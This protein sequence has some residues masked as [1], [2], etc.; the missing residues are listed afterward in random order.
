MREGGGRQEGCCVGCMHLIRIVNVPGNFCIDYFGRPLPPPATAAPTCG[1]DRCRRT[2][3]AAARRVPRTGPN[4]SSGGRCSSANAAGGCTTKEAAAPPALS[5]SATSTRASCPPSVTRCPCSTRSTSCGSARTW[6]RWAW[7]SPGCSPSYAPRTA[8]HTVHS[9]HHLRS[10][11]CRLCACTVCVAQVREPAELI[12][13]DL[14]P[15]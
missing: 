12:S 9:H 11:H 15:S 6:R 5:L 13:L 2:A 1:V 14:P 4:A 8:T 10:V 7:L 3:R